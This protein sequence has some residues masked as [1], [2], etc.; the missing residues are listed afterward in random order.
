MK[1]YKKLLVWQKGIDIC[2]ET[3]KLTSSIPAFEKFG[4]VSQM[5]RAAVSI[6]SNI[7]EGSSRKSEKDYYRF[8]EIA[9]GSCFEL[10]TQCVILSEVQLAQNDSIERLHTLLDEEAMML[11]SLMKKMN[12]Y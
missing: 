11:Q 6:P 8:L 10:E 7:A 9:L 4:I 1:D 3:Y 5:N 12:V 2:K